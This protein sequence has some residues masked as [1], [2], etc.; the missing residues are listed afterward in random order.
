MFNLSLKKT[1]NNGC[2]RKREHVDKSQQPELKKKYLI[3]SSVNF[4]EIEEFLKK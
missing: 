3:I 2:E 4:S 1:K